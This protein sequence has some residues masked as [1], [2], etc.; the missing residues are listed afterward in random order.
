M[1]DFTNRSNGGSAKVSGGGAGRDFTNR[2]NN[3]SPDRSNSS[4]A[5]DL[6]NAGYGAK[7]PRSKGFTTVVKNKSL[8]A[9]FHGSDPVQSTPRSFTVPGAK[10]GKP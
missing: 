3:G 1:A 2:Y 7:A 6:T 10:R 4:K 8:A 5:P 9:P